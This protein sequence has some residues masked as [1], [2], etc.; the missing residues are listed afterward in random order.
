MISGTPDEVRDQLREY[1]DAGVDY[2]QINFM[3][4]PDSGSGGV[5]RGDCEGLRS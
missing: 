4:F 5:V 3:D 1:E 2:M